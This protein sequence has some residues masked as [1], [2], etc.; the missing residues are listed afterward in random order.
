MITPNIHEATYLTGVAIKS[1]S[2]MQEAAECLLNKGCKAVLMKGGHLVDEEMVDIL[3]LPNEQPIR[4]ASEVIQTNNTHGTGCTLSSAIAAYLTLGNPLAE[5]VQLAKK[6]IIEA[7]NTGAD[8][9]VGAGHGPVNHAFN[10]S[11][12]QKISVK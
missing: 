1:S 2:D 10:P 5:A 7:L 9:R 12:L 8:V 6:Y 11:P 3:F 4:M